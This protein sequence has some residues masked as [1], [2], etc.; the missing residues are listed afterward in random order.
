M[1]A[2]SSILVIQMYVLPIEAYGPWVH[3]HVIIRGNHV[4]QL[5]CFCRANYKN[6]KGEGRKSYLISKVSVTCWPCLSNY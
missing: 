3:I 5:Y 2:V 6:T 4:I 1:K